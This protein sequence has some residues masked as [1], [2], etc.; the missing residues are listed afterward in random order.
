MS[1]HLPSVAESYA[2][3]FDGHLSPGRKPA[4]LVVDL[5]IAYSD[6]ASP[7]YCE[8]A[9]AAIG[10]NR[11]LLAAARENGVPVIATNVRY[12]P[13]GADG[14]L[15]YRKVPA[16]SVFDE[17]SP[18]GSFPEG[19]DVRPDEI[20]TKQFPS[21]FFRTGLADKLREAGVDMVLIT[22]FSTSGCVRASAVDA[23]QEGFAPFVILDAC[24][25]RHPE[26]HEA[27]L[28]DLQ[29][30]YAEVISARDALG[31]MRTARCHRDGRRLDPNTT[32]LPNSL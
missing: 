19:F 13:G 17:G 29:A 25:D 8:T 28:R 16:L 14:G 26:P 18:L 4:L 31:I 32:T 24:A 30:K 20:L 1:D 22:G 5:V 10:V 21:A 9:D 27:N 6:R 12:Q 15:F 7:L 2:G 23:I 3:S 11:A